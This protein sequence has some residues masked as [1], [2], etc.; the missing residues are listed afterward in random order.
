MQNKYRGRRILAAFICVLALAA[1][2]IL[3]GLVTRLLTRST[4][5]GPDMTSLSN[6]RAVELTNSWGNYFTTTSDPKL[7]EA[8]LADTIAE[9]KAC[10]ANTLLLTGWIKDDG[11]L[12]RSGGKNQSPAAA[13]AIA[14]NDSF[15]RTWDPFKTLIKLAS[16]QEVQLALLATDEQG[17]PLLDGAELPGFLQAAAKEYKLAVYSQVSGGLNGVYNYSGNIDVPPLLRLDANPAILAAVWQRNASYGLVLGSLD[18]LSVDPAPALRLLS[19]TADG[20]VTAPLMEK[21]LAR[22]LAILSP[23]PAV[24]AYGDGIYLIGTS[25]PTVPLTINGQEPSARSPNGVWGIA[26]PLESGANNYSAVQGEST[27]T[28][29]VNRGTAGGGTGAA[30]PD[31]SVAALGGQK[32]R[33]TTTLASLLSDYANNDAISMTAYEGGV[34]TVT[35]ST[36]FTRS[37]KKTYA[38]KLQNGAYVLAKDCELLPLDAPDA[39]FDGLSV[40]TEGNME[41]LSFSGSGTPIYTHSWDGN[42]FAITFLSTT[43]TGELPAS[44]NFE[45]ASVTA[46]AA[47]DGCVTLVFEFTDADPLFGYH[48]DY[49]EGGSTRIVLKHQPK[50][51]ENTQKPLTGITVM[52]DPGH[53]DSDFGA[54]GCV[55]TAVPQE[56]DVNLALSL[57]A[58]TRLE[59]LGATVLMTRDT[60]VFYSLG[61][62]LEMLN[63]A[64]PDFFIAVHHNSTVLNRDVSELSGTECYWFYTNGKQLAE[65]LVGG[66]CAATGRIDRGIHYNYFYVT[67]SNICPAVL[68]ETGFVSNPLEFDQCTDEQ[69]LWMSGGT[70]AEAVLATLPQ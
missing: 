12:F 63:A 32:L 58:R 20:E 34:A 27:V 69:T 16:E 54:F 23:N 70:I 68:L 21:T 55:D 59:Q 6:V 46:G 19:Y 62:R 2:V 26:L 56:K 52:L 67:R 25:D 17:N 11:V 47:E 4:S 30:R 14:Q 39:A 57:A 43:F 8:Y 18:A 36:L 5:F 1:L 10:G 9:A 3:F 31:G 51:A 66:V 45:G 22:T 64:K 24:L 61:E 13:E 65:N 49:T 40:S 15:F 48:V 7:Q 37:G 44:F 50:R 33:I 42:H 38:Y 53:G 29:T 28:I 35:G 41:Y 60:D